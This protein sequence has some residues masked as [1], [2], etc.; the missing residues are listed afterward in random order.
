MSV[1]SGIGIVVK[2]GCVVP[3]RSII[4]L[5]PR[6]RAADECLLGGSVQSKIGVDVKFGCLVSV[7]SM[8]GLDPRVRPT[9][10]GDPLS[11][12]SGDVESE[13]SGDRD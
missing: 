13:Y 11:G 6:S 2:S 12:T 8:L 5:D 7:R 9:D 4:G 1:D 10:K 3:V